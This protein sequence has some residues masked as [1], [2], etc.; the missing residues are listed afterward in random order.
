MGTNEKGSGGTYLIGEAAEKVGLS[1]K[2]I[3]YYEET[4]LLPK[5][6]RRSSDDSVGPGY[7]TYTE[8]D[9]ERLRFVKLVRHLELPLADIKRLLEVVK[10]GCCGSAQPQFLSLITEK[11]R[12]TEEEMRD[13]QHLRTRLRGLKGTMDGLPSSKKQDQTE[14][15]SSDIPLKCVTG[16]T[17]DAAQMEPRSRQRQG[18]PGRGGK[19]R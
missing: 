18:K 19:R 6:H 15:P 7:R 4:G 3:R 16:G 1:A 9:I 14:C 12:Q 2:T 8:D 13:L 17:L 5:A 11:L 10:E